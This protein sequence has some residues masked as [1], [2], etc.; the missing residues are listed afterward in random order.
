[1]ESIRRCEDCRRIVRGT[2]GDACPYCGSGRLIQ[3]QAAGPHSFRHASVLTLVLTLSIGLVLFRIVLIATGSPAYGE[4]LF[5]LQF[6]AGIAAIFYLILRRSEG[7][8]R[9][10]LMVSLG[11]FLAT[12]VTGALAREYGMLALNKLGREFNLTLFIFSGIA[13]TA[14]VADGRRTDRFQASLIAANMG[15]LFLAAIRTIFH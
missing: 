5:P 10:L 4:L 14:A 2:A 8:F 3:T 12:E 1:M 15:L 9:A 11:L 13:I 6:T 7:D